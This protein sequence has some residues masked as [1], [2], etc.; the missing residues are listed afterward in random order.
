[1]ANRKKGKMVVKVGNWGY[2]WLIF[3]IELLVYPRVNVFCDDFVNFENCVMILFIF[4]GLQKKHM[5]IFGA[6]YR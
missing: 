1:M 6:E 2:R 3:H 5:M 4:L